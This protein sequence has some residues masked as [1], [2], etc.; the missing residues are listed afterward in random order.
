MSQSRNCFFVNM[1]ND[2]L[3]HN[4]AMAIKAP[5]LSFIVLIPFL[6]IGAIYTIDNVAD[7]LP[8]L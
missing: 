1:T 4:N 5:C 7:Q 6:P 2:K 8:L 3:R